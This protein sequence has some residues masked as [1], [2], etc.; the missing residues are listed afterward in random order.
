V[1]RPDVKVARGVVPP[2]MSSGISK[3]SSVNLIKKKTYKYTHPLKKLYPVP[4]D[5][6]VPAFYRFRESGCSPGP[7]FEPIRSPNDFNE[8]AQV[9][10]GSQ[11]GTQEATITKV[12][13]P[14]IYYEYGGQIDREKHQNILAHTGSVKCVFFRKNTKDEIAMHL[15]NIDDVGATSSPSCEEQVPIDGANAL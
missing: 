2:A 8:G 10:V 14:I 6:F 11:E 15:D 5:M 4:F 3:C 7:G 12:D 1:C 9:W 13:W